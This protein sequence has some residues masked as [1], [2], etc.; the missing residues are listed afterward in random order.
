MKKGIARIFLFE[1]M[2]QCSVADYA[3]AC[4]KKAAADWKNLSG[5]RDSFAKVLAL[6][7]SFLMSIYVINTLLFP[8]K[9]SKKVVSKRISN[10][11]D[12]LGIPLE[13]LKLVKNV[14]V[15]NSFV[16]MDERLDKYLDAV[17]QDRIEPF[18]LSPEEPG[19][20]TLVIRRFDPDGLTISTLGGKNES[21]RVEIELERL[22]EEINLILD[23]VNRAFTKLSGFDEDILHKFGLE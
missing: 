10:L 11:N 21:S 7:S 6:C 13:K 18:S 16:H 3:F 5:D 2:M 20:G 9:R 4:L 17:A 19:A 12:L 22:Y 8:G 1:L 15:R 14:S 23:G